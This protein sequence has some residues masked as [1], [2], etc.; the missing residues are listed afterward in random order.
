MEK[1]SRFVGLDVHAETIAVAVAEPSGEVRADD[2][3]L[4]A[5]H[6]FEDAAAKADRPV[7]G[8]APEAAKLLMAYLWQGRFDIRTTLTPP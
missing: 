8:I 1:D 7:T 3:L 5:Q 6:F 4:L 2:V